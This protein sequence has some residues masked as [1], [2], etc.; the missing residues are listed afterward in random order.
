MTTFLVEVY[1]PRSDDAVARATADSARDV[2]QALSREGVPVEFVRWMYVPDDE[3]EFLLFEAP[4]KQA[5]LEVIR[6]AELPVERLAVAIVQPGREGVLP[7]GTRGR[8][9]TSTGR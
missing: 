9:S 1:L 8:Q 7:G 2:A 5:V 6:R 4:S 3:T